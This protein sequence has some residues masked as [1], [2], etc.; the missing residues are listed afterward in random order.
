MLPGVRETRYLE[1]QMHFNSGK[2]SDPSE[3]CTTPQRTCSC[4][5]Q[6][7]CSRKQNPTEG[8]QLR[9]KHIPSFTMFLALVGIYRIMYCYNHR[10]SWAPYLLFHYQHLSEALYSFCHTTDTSAINDLELCHV[11][12]IQSV[13]HC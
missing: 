12:V 1:R 9:C 4:M 3:L 10:L 11:T 8:N 7:Y 2:S 6:T 13:H 5:T